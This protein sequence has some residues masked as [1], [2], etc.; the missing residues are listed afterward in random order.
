MRLVPTWL[1]TIIGARMNINF[2]NEYYAQ[3]PEQKPTD[4][5]NK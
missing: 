3:H 2:R 1:R 4:L 5:I